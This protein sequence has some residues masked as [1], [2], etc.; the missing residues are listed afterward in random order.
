MRILIVVLAVV[1]LGGAAFG[2][3]ALFTQPLPEI[4]SAQEA[5]AAGAGASA[6]NDLYRQLQGDM[7]IMREKYER[8]IS[9]LEERLETQETEIARLNKQVAQLAAGTPAAGVAPSG[10]AGAVPA[11]AV[12]IDGVDRESLKQLLGEL[13]E[14]RRRDDNQ[15][16]FER[17]QTETAD[18]KSRQVDKVA[19]KFKWDEAKKQQVLDVLAQER[20]KTQELWQQLREQ[21]L[22]QESRQELGKQMRQ[23]NEE[24]QEALK[25]LLSEEEYK[26]IQKS[27]RSRRE[28]SPGRG[29]RFTP[30]RG[31]GNR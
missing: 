18:R 19:E 9:N 29:S 13:S 7:G 17:M 8:S 15:K 14:E 16:R 4:D 5:E 27:L 25:A 2:S 12:R 26:D 22:S 3:Y 28:R 11:S 30:G 20:T 24:T 10:E 23:I 1:A 6:G 31:G 21:G